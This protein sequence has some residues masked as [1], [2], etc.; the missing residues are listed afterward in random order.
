MPHQ[1][2]TL[3]HQLLGHGFDQLHAL[4]PS[5]GPLWQPASPQ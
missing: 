3:Q 1:P 2:S 4:F 5:H